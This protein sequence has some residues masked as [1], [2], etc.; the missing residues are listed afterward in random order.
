MH[1]FKIISKLNIIGFVKE[2]YRLIKLFFQLARESG[3]RFLIGF[4]LLSISISFLE[5]IGISFGINFIFKDSNQFFNYQLETNNTLSYLLILLILLI[6]IL[7]NFFKAYLKTFKDDIR[8][9]LLNDM[10][11]KVL[12]RVLYT[13]K[14]KLKSTGKNEIHNTLLNEISRAV[15]ALDKGLQCIQ[16]LFTALIYLIALLKIYS[17]NNL[18][19]IF[20]GILSPIVALFFNPSFSYY[21]GSLITKSNKNIQNIIGESINGLKVLKVS[22]SENWFIKNFIKEKIIYRKTSNLL[23]KKRNNYEAFRDSTLLCLI[24]SWLLIYTKELSQSLLIST[25][26]FAY[27][28]TL[29]ISSIVQSQRICFESLP[30][31][32][33][34]VKLKKLINEQEYKSFFHFSKEDN[35]IKQQLNFTKNILWRNKIL[36]ELSIDKFELTKGKIC[37]IIG[38]S[39]SGKTTFLD[40]FFGLDNS[41]S[42]SWSFIGENFTKEFCDINGAKF[43]KEITSYSLQNPYLFEK[44]IIDNILLGFNKSQDIE[45]RIENWLDRLSLKSLFSNY[46]NLKN[47]L[48]I[49]VNSLSGGE[50]QRINLLRTF[51]KD[52]PIELYDEPTSF[53]DD[54]LAYKVIDIIMERSKNKFLLIATHDKY[55]IKKADVIISLSDFKVKISKN[56]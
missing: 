29:T 31:Y 53:L 21:Y 1:S 46:G 16:G 4:S 19:P 43:M 36:D 3:N 49:M 25:F 20:I 6:L 23:V 50:I 47:D 8:V 54:K 15:L 28:I 56:S 2:K 24:T 5:V 44:S 48:K 30:G 52:N 55:L 51:I 18:F 22:S 27:K 38:P 40:T 7:R 14:S 10:R 37:V 41:E 32:A 35:D 11:Q 34:V 42:S 26:F 13:Q 39:G 33:E 9:K 45:E 17:N 12:T